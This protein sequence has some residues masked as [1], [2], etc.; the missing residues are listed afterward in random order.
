MRFLIHG[1][2][3]PEVPAALVKRG[4]ACHAL[5]ELA[6]DAGAGAPEAAALDPAIL[7]PLL[8]KR[9]WNLLTTDAALVRALYEKKVSYG[10]MIVLVLDDPKAPR[11][12]GRA[13]ERLFERYPR[14][15]PGRL[16]TVT[17]SR[18]KIR[19]LPGAGMRRG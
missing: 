17:A 1:A 11:D 2:V 12:Q 3:R 16:Y 8:E 5:P 4:H 7:L 13:I 10:G 9:Q 6:V 18:V 15:T 19:Q 14:L